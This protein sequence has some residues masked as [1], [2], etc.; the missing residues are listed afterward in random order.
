[1]PL[2][3]TEAAKTELLRKAQADGWTGIG[4]Y[5]IQEGFDDNLK[6]I[7]WRHMARGVKA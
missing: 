6:A 7:V 1:M 2:G 3:D 5:M 4:G